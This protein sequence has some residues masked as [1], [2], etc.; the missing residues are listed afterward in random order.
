MQQVN[1]LELM[2]TE[3]TAVKRPDLLELIQWWP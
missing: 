1:Q 2:T 3:S